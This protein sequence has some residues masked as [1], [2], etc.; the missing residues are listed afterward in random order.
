[1]TTPDC[2]ATTPSVS[3]RISTTSADASRPGRPADHVRL[4]V[5]FGLRGGWGVSA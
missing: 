1:M 4:G 2:T 5:G 3:P